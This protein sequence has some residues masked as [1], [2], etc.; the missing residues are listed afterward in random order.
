MSTLNVLNIAHTN[1]TVAAVITTDGKLTNLVTPTAAGDAANKSY[2]DSSTEKIQFL[3]ASVASNALTVTLNPTVLSFR[4]ST[5]TSGVVN[6]RTI[7]SPI[8]LTVPSG[9]TLGTVNAT[10]AKLILIAIDNAGT[11][12]LA[13]VNIAGGNAL[14][15]TGVISTTILDTASDSASVIYSTTARSNVPYRVV[16]FVDSTQT[17]AGTWAAAMTTI[18]GIGGQA[19]AA[20]S[21]IGYGQTWQNLTGSRALAT[22]YTNTT[23]K[24]IFISVRNTGTNN[25]SLDV[26][27][28]G[29]TV[30]SSAI[31]PD[32]FHHTGTA[33]VPPGATYSATSSS[34]LNS[35]HE[36]R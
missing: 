10:L 2:V 12:E 22:T 26:V 23:G 19:L 34:A 16:G 28:N 9:A 8:S 27:V 30:Y 31:S 25:S 17:T 11:V 7:A 4:S 18:Q 24:P 36:L 15:E 13:I 20:L 32:A 6:V 3:S 35:W 1:G 29:F 21:S 14:D 33:I 5:L